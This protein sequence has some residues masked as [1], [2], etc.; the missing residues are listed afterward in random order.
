[1]TQLLDVAIEHKVLVRADRA[2]VYDAF[3]TA[4][5]L[6]G[7]FTVGSTV[8]ARPGGTIHFRWQDW[9]PDRIT[10]ESSGPVREAERPTRFVFD[11]HGDNDSYYTTVAVDFTATEE[12]TVM[13]LRETGYEDTPGG[14]KSILG[15]ATGWSEALT[16]LKFY[17]E[18]GLRY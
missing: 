9:G 3:T 11:W 10:A 4:A 7:W 13:L 12:G 14:R 6:D 17:V 5:G 18:H 15:C 1:M 16:L 8:E 2:R